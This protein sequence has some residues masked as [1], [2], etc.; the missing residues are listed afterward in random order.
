M[1]FDLPKD[2]LKG[3]QDEQEY[4]DAQKRQIYENR[5]RIKAIGKYVADLL[6]KDVY[7]QI[8]GTGKAMLAVYSIKSAIAYKEAVS[9]EFKKMVADP[10]FAKYK[11]APIHIVYSANQDEQSASGLNDGLTEEKVLQNFAL[12]KNGLIIVVAKLQTGFDEKKLHTLF[13]DKEVTGI[14]AIQT[15]SRVNRTAKYK[16]DCKIVDFSYN[17]V[18][19]QN[20]KDAFKHY[21]D[22]V[23]SDWDP[24]ADNTLF[25]DL[26]KRLLKSEVYA[27]FFPPF[28][29]ILADAEKAKDP[30]SFLDWESKLEKFI[31]AHP[32]RAADVKAK[33]SQYFTILNRIEYVISLDAKY[34]DATLLQ[35]LRR[36]NTIYNMLNRSENVKDPIE[37]YFD[38]QIG[39]IETPAEESKDKKRKP[40]KM[41]EGKEPGK[42][43]EFDI[44]AIIEA[45]NEQQAALAELIKDFAAKIRDLFQFIVKSPDGERLV[46]KINSN[47]AEAEIYDDFAKLYRRYK[48]LY[49]KQVGDYFFKETEDLVEKLCDDFEAEVR[50]KETKVEDGAQ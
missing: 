18:N 30:E 13:L 34:S 15:I 1:L 47:V 7:R 45:R 12:A 32:K 42:Q 41:A 24:F 37:V 31:A 2:K 22:V 33:T 9:A 48:A 38:N 25:E 20:I 17:N 40:I 16:N 6:V 26:Y 46:V 5:D 49:R 11:D 3:F 50:D 8:R 21:A 23:V 14:S 35:F 10:K 19:V 27:K 39:I 29:A 28:A 44:L 36:Y 4:K 43:H